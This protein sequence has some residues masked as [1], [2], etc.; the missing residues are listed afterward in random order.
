MEPRV[1]FQVA[2]CPIDA[3]VVR[4]LIGAGTYGKVYRTCLEGDCNVV[5]KVQVLSQ[6]DPSKA[7]K[8]SYEELIRDFDNEAALAKRASDGGYGPRVLLACRGAGHA[9]NELA[10]A[11]ELAVPYEVG[12]IAM[13]RW[14]G[15]L[16]QLAWCHSAERSAEVARLLEAKVAAM[17][18]DNVVHAD[19]QPANVFYRL[20]GRRVV[21]LAIGDYGYAFDL[22]QPHE[23]ALIEQMYKWNYYDGTTGNYAQA[24][25]LLSQERLE[26]V[27]QD[28]SMLDEPMLVMARTCAKA[29]ADTS[30]RRRTA[31][32]RQTKTKTTAEST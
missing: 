14:D 25:P 3:V 29:R 30:P 17:R 16:R 18:A 23:R 22:T 32:T 13:E 20:R 28:P 12:L 1:E 27:L 6:P 8:Q 19:L 4:E 10:L 5:V 31:P 15:S 7:S 11:L 26:D 2:R 21:D 9:D 24:D